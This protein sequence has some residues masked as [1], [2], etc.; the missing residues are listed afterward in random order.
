MNMMKRPA[1]YFA[2]VL[3]AAGLAVFSHAVPRDSSAA[4]NAKTAGAQTGLPDL[5]VDQKRLLQNWV[6]RDEDL[7]STF[8]SVEEGG[9]TPGQHTLIRFTVST[10]NIR[11][12]V[13]ALG[14]PN[15][16][17]AAGDGLYE[18]ATCHRHYHFKHYTLYELIDPQTGY[19]WKAATRGIC[20]IDVEKYQACPGPTNNDRNYRSRGA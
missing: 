15:A 9:V 11:D 1:I 16:H 17:V 18:F 14:D 20:L 8:C 2:L 5:I 6:V 19:V 3:L 4:V 10:P 7:K 12:A 13:L